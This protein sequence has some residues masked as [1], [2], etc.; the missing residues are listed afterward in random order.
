MKI[1]KQGLFTGERALYDIHDAEIIDS[2]FDGSTWCIYYFQSTGGLIANNIVK[3]QGVTGIFNFQTPNT[4][5]RNNTV[6]NAKNH[7]IDVRHMV[8]PNVKVINNKIVG[9]KEGIYLLHSGKHTVTGNTIVNCSLSSITCCGANNILIEN[10]TLQNSRIGVLLS[11]SAP[12]GG[13]YV[14]YTNITIGN[15]NWKLDQLPFP[16]SFVF[17]VAEAKSDDS[18]SARRMGAYDRR[19]VP[20]CE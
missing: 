11:G 1:Y 8:G 4:I 3:N 14:G 2:T 15:N 13:S 16:P 9:A 12:V 7:G 19:N 17:Y 18:V 20:D 10:N 6:I 5:I